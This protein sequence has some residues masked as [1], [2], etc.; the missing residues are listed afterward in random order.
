MRFDVVVIGAGPAGLSAAA[1]LSRT[2][3]CLLLDRGPLA[4][5]RD[6]VDD[7]LSGVGG[8]GL[9]SDG[10]HSFFPSATALWQLPD[11]EA[12]HGAFEATSALLT[13]HGVEVS[14]SDATPMTPEVWNEKRYPSLYVP[15]AERLACIDELWNMCP[16]RFAGA[17]V[18]DI[19]GEVLHVRGLGE[20]EAK[21]LVIAT[22]RWSPRALR[23]LLEKRGVRYAFQRD[24]IGVRIEAPADHPLFARLPG[25]D[26]KLVLREAETE[27]RTFCTCR[28]GEVLL[29]RADGLQA[30]SGRA[31]G[32][33]TGRS[34][35]GLVVRGRFPGA[36]RPVPPLHFPIAAWEPRTLE[37]MFGRA[38]SEALHHAMHRLRELVN[39]DGATIHAPVIEGVGDYPVDDG[40]QIADRTWIAGDACGRFRGIVA[41]MVS[42]RYV[43]RQ[44]A[45]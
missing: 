20:I 8:A 3:S 37:P 43:A 25:V 18:D 44:I 34:N 31:D 6:R 42:G 2:R 30:F 13:R 33:K 21:H 28:N 26:G 41:S 35:V 39:L 7:V 36:V 12:L 15:F 23:P 27:I 32:P 14:R 24:E 22:G 5:E 17:E 40:L 38:G 4:S 16:D 29:G 11:R 19:D 45:R 1:E 10:K 9:F